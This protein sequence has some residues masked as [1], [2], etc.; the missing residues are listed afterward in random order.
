MDGPNFAHQGG[1]SQRTTEL[2]SCA[3]CRKLKKKCGKQIPTCANCDKNGAHCSY[4]G[5]APRRTKKELADA[6][7]RGEY[8]P[9]KRN[10][11]VGKSPLSTKSMPNSS[12]PLSANGAITP[13]FSPYENDDAH[14][15]KQLKPSDPINLVMGQVQIL[16][17]VSHR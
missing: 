9:V 3:R 5:R 13:E 6:M 4:P 1:R 14:K 8:V 16:A 17:K 12:S 11:K 7:L 10:K 2:Y 15:M